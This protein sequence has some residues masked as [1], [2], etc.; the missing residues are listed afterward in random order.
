[1]VCV[2]NELAYVFIIISKSGSFFDCATSLDG[3]EDFEKI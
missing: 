3:N 2:L 1:L